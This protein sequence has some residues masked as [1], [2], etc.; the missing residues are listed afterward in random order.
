MT[1]PIST[2]SDATRNSGILPIRRR[3]FTLIELLVVIAIIAILAA[4]LIPA[5]SRAKEKANRTICLNNLKQLLLGHI[6][7]GTDYNDFIAHPNADSAYSW[8]STTPGGDQPGFLYRTGNTPSGLPNGVPAGISWTLLGPEGGAFWS[9]VSKGGV[10]GTSV[11]DIGPSHKVPQ[12]WKMYQCPLDPPLATAGYFDSRR[13]KFSSYVMNWGAANYS[14]N[15]QQKIA[16]FRGSSI[17]LWEADCTTNNP[18]QNQYKDGAANGNEGIGQQHGGK[19]GNIGGMDGHAGF[20]S[21]K[22]FYD[23]AADRNKN[24]LWIANDSADGR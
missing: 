11:N 21:Y 22:S 23:M 15:K 16:S 6:M 13:M 17:L 1:R 7:Y 4:M 12:V 5:L 14:R 8:V 18:A 2:K 19:G 24:D 20:L 10:T 3:A 9:Y